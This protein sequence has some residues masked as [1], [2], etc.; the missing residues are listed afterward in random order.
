MHTN[1]IESKTMAVDDVN[2][3]IYRL[4]SN[5]R[6]ELQKKYMNKWK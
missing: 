2:K 4:Q 3:T 5:F 6:R 1:Y